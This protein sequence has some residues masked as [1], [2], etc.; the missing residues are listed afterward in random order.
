MSKV[1]S[2]YRNRLSIKGF[3]FESEQFLYLPF[4][5]AAQ[6]RCTDNIR[7]IPLLCCKA[8]GIFQES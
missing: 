6:V 7:Y 3:S 8:K 2:F 1:E 4:V 5:L